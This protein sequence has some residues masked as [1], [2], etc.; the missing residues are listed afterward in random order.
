MDARDLCSIA[1]CDER[2]RNCNEGADDEDSH[3][4]TKDRHLTDGRSYD[5]WVRATV[6]HLVRHRIRTS[7]AFLVCFRDDH[8]FGKP[9]RAVF[10]DFV[11]PTFIFE[12]RQSSTFNR[13]PATVSA[14]IDVRH[15]CGTYTFDEFHVVGQLVEDTVIVDVD[16]ELR[17]FDILLGFASRAKTKAMK[18]SVNPAIVMPEKK[19]RFFIAWFLQVFLL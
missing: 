13:N 7:S 9:E 8:V 12:E 6:L 10:C 4:V 11:D 1:T 3:H 18:D 14:E 17:Y 16:R 2:N 19:K 5:L 15:A